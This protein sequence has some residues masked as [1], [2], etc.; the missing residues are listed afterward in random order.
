MVS[1]TQSF[2]MA[3]DPAFTKI[4]I[5][6]DDSMFFTLLFRVIGFNTSVVEVKKAGQVCVKVLHGADMVP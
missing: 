5:I 2:Y 6:D 1:T 4:K 3:I